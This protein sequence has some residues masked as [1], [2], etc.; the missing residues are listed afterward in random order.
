LTGSN[1]V[2]GQ[3]GNG[4]VSLRQITK[5]CGFSY[6]AWMNYPGLKA[7]LL[8]FD[9]EDRSVRGLEGAG[10]LAMLRRYLRGLAQ[11]DEPLPIRSKGTPGPNEVRIARTAGFNAR[12]FRE[13]PAKQRELA[14]RTEIPAIAG[15]RIPT[16]YCG[17]RSNLKKPPTGG[18]FIGS[19]TKS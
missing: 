4:F 6:N 16:G 2:F 17:R 12:A 5:A 3:N 7:R 15:Y 13:D 18:F 1:S 11:R 8:E 9:N 19:V 14:S 10:P